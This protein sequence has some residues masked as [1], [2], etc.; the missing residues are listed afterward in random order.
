MGVIGPV[1]FSGGFCGPMIGGILLSSVGYWRTWVLPIAMIVLDLMMRLAMTERPTPSHDAN[2]VNAPCD[3]EGCA[4]TP[5]EHSRSK[6]SSQIQE[7]SLQATQSS[8]EPQSGMSSTPKTAP[9]LASTAVE[10][11]PLLT[12]LPQPNTLPLLTKPMSNADYFFCI[13]R[14]RRI[15][16]SFFVTLILSVAYNSFATTLALHV[17]HVFGWGPRE[18]GYLFLALVSPS[19]LLGPFTGYLRDLVG[20]RW[21]TMVGTGIAAPLFILL[22]YVGD[23]KF[24][25]TQGELGKVIC[26]GDLIMMGIA[27]ELSE[28]VCT[29]EGP[30]TWIALSIRGSSEI[31]DAE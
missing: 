24:H 8:S 22:G 6:S 20:V 19:V 4:A 27:V 7:A 2:G 30:R 10:A 15:I 29:I 9:I 16:S 26:I 1:V 11:T 18:V 17:E 3:P 21:P 23:E 13:F 12:A 31:L 5:H 14:H 25:W 28:G